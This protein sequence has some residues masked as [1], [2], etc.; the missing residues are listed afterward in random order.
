VTRCDSDNCDSVHH[1]PS[2]LSP[3]QAEALFI[4]KN[5]SLVRNFV[6]VLL[7]NMLSSIINFKQLRQ[8]AAALGA[9][10]QL[11]HRIFQKTL[12]E[13]LPRS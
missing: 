6:I 8:V 7:K 13:Q 3:S 12:E 5:Y 2:P 10:K 1:T 9:A 11:H 4:A